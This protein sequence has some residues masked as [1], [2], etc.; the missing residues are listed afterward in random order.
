M[1]KQPASIEPHDDPFQH[2]FSNAAHIVLKRLEHFRVL[3]STNAFVKARGEAGEDEGLVV[4]ADTQTTGVGRLSRFW[5]SPLG[6][7]YFSFLLRPSMLA[8]SEIQLI[9][10][11]AGVAVAKVLQQA[12]GL[13]A[14]LKWPNDVLLGELKVAG[15]L[16]EQSLKGSEVE[17][18]VVGIGVNVNTPL[19]EFPEDLKSKVSS[20]QEALKRSIDLPRL[21]GYLIGQLEYWYLRLRDKGFPAIAPHWR[22]LCNHLGRSVTISTP[23]GVV[24]G[25]AKD[26]APDG[27][28]I[29]SSPTGKQILWSG[30]LDYP[31]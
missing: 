28:L 4:L 9:T 18:T 6:G 23:E 7:L 14:S 25:I 12:Y 30:D 20:L 29:I 1:A 16:A 17:F 13:K 22:K 2:V 31:S 10:L 24:Q 11:A 27:S 3:A 26:I 21:F 8:P 5:R 15:I 19:D